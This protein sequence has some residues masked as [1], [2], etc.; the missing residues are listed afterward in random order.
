[1]NINRRSYLILHSV[2]CLAVLGSVGILLGLFSKAAS[3]STVFLQALAL[4]SGATVPAMDTGEELYKQSCLSCHAADGHGSRKYPDIAGDK[5]KRNYGTYDKAYDFISTNM[6]ENAPG[7]LHDEEYK[8]IVRYVLGLNG[9]PSEFADIQGH[10]AYQSIVGLQDKG[11]IDG[12]TEQG[13]LLYKPDQAI[14]R[15]QFITY[16]V[17]AKELFLSNHSTSSMTDIS[18]SNR[19]TY[20]ITAIEYGLIDGYPDATFRPDKP[21]N[22]AEIATVLTRSE[23]LTAAEDAGKSQVSFKDVS[24]SHW[25]SAT[26]QAASA[27][28]LFNGY[29]DGTFRP[30]NPITRAE[31]AAVIYRIVRLDP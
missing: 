4:Q 21:I 19:K 1:M 16:L 28:G 8:A 13:K 10:W 29:E 9:I 11:Y 26:I 24:V 25:A 7:S 30:D 31:A 14:T 27:S 22:R 15:E 5:F 20:L 2:V 18:Q 3:P 17:K 12:F 23:A 6:P